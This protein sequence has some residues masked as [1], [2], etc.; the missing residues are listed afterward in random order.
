MIDRRMYQEGEM[1]CSVM[2]LRPSR[3]IAGRQQQSREDSRRAGAYEA[4]ELETRLARSGVGHLSLRANSQNTDALLPVQQSASI[5]K[6]DAPEQLLAWLNRFNLK[7][8]Q[9][10]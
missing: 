3:K 9:Q 10:Q 8:F 7:I 2:K 4:F 5:T 1:R 6:R